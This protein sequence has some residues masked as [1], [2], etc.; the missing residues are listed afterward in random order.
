MAII[1]LAGLAALAGCATPPASPAPVQSASTPAAVTDAPDAVPAPTP[2]ALADAEA[3]DGAVE[4]TAIGPDSPIDTLAAWAMCKGLGDGGNQSLH[5]LTRVYEPGNITP[6]DD[7]FV[8]QLL[9]DIGARNA[10]DSWCD[11]SGTFGD[12]QATFHLLQ[13]EPSG[14]T[15][16][17][18]FAAATPAVGVRTEGS[19]MDALTAWAVCKGFERGLSLNLEAETGTPTNAYDPSLVIESDGTFTAYILGSVASTEQTATCTVSGPLGDPT[20]DYLLPR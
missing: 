4:V 1:S 19:P 10:T 13:A 6:T 15:A 14:L 18:P 17:A 5:A 20:V 16:S 8:V 7:G 2:T 12:P 9:G 11:V 3:S